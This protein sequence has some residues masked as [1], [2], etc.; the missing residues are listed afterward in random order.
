M[1]K[2][3]LKV[4]AVLA[5]TGLA[6]TFAGCS[7]STSSSAGGGGE[8]KI[9]TFG[10]YT[11]DAATDGTQARDGAMLAVEQIN[12]KGGVIG[13]QIKLVAM[14]DQAKAPEAMNVVTKMIQQEKVSALVSGSYST[15]S[16]TVAPV[17]QQN[18]IPMV[19]AYAVNPAIT[20]GGN[21]IFRTIYAGPAQGAAM[22]EYAVKE[23]NLKKVAV[24]NVNND[25]GNT[26][27]EGFTNQIKKLGG[28]VVISRN[29]VDGTKDFK[30]LLTAVKEKNPEAIYIGS[31]YNE[32]AQIC[33][34]AK[35]LGIAVPIFGSDGFDSPKLTELGGKNVEGVVFTTPFFREEPRPMVQD[36]IKAYKE[37]FD[38]EPDML[39]AQAYDSVL[40]LADAIKRANSTDK[41]AIRKA[42]S[43]TKGFEGVTGKI[44]FD[45]KNEV[46]KPVI[47]S[48][49]ENGKFVYV[50]SQEYTK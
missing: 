25:Y 29:F 49:V 4:I 6:S 46:I 21:Y 36:F 28:E 15:P 24:L 27:A 42:L 45:E 48:R 35:Q 7:T 16:K 19:V 47:L 30:A 40:V 33:T 17:V 41:E 2:N 44:S 20:E 9:G 10:P 3:L 18:K 11:G 32:A 26:N 22:A 39:S 14:D 12:K 13:K 5:I 38:K 50:K 31:Y 43:E 8:I 34:Q 23:K 37:K 1:K